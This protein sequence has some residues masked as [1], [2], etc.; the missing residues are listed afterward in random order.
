MTQGSPGPGAAPSIEG[1]WPCCE[2]CCMAVVARQPF[3]G[4]RSA[5][6][7]CQLAGHFGALTLALAAWQ[8]S[9]GH[10]AAQ[11]WP[12]AQREGR[13]GPSLVGPLPPGI[14][15]GHCQAGGRPAPGLRWGRSWAGL[16]QGAGCGAPGTLCS[17]SRARR[18]R[19]PGCHG[20]AREAAPGAG[21]AGRV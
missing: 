1:Q 3:R 13:Q 18:R 16:V 9:S 15:R 20:R 10:K 17:S 5:A 14:L 21:A 4:G 12:S 11:V 8:E 19:C 6:R 2:E 7:G